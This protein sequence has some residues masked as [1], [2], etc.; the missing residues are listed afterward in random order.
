MI[1]SIIYT[2]IEPFGNVFAV[3]PRSLNISGPGT[4]ISETDSVYLSC[5]VMANP[6]PTWQWIKRNNDTRSNP[7]TYSSRIRITNDYDPFTAISISRLSVSGAVPGD[8]GD[9]VCEVFNN[10][11]T[12]NMIYE[13]VDVDITRE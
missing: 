6:A 11:T 1:L 10:V 7:E 5:M 8:V 9:Y 13:E 4:A 3:S 2:I 12:Q